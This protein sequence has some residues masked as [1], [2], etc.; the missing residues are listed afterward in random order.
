MD[1]SEAFDCLQ[2]NPERWLQVIGAPSPFIARD[3]DGPEQFPKGTNWQEDSFILKD[4]FSRVSL[5][6]SVP[7][8]GTWAEEAT[9]CVCAQV[10]G[11][12]KV[13]S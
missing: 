9:L 11:S 10:S 3:Q 12:T 1:T 6:V 4:T 8:N 7:F 2:V 13:N 5:V